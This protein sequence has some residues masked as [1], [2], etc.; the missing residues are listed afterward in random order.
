MATRKTK[1]GKNYQRI[2]KYG[3]TTM[4]EDLQT[5]VKKVTTEYE[6]EYHN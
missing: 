4:K 1:A 6:S 3:T 2:L 5:V